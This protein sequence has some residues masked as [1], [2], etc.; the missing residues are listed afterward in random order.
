M[1]FTFFFLFFDSYRHKKVESGNSKIQDFK[2][3]CHFFEKKKVELQLSKEVQ[4]IPNTSEREDCKKKMMMKVGPGSGN[5]SFPFFCC[6][7][8]PETRCQFA[9]DVIMVARTLNKALGSKNIGLT[10]ATL[11]RQQGLNISKSNSRICLF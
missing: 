8:E 11:I 7:R 6:S 10:N 9:I 1:E 5:L 2:S 3:G 4:V